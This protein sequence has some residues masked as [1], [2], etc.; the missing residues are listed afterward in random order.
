MLTRDSNVTNAVAM[1]EA[2]FA[3]LFNAGRYEQLIAGFYAEDAKLLPP[4]MPAVDGRSAIGRVFPQLAQIFSDLKI[5]TGPVNVS[6]ELAVT[7]GTYT[8]KL[9]LA[10]GKTV[11]DQGKFMEAWRKE[12]DGSWKCILDTFSS[13]NVH[14]D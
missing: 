14:T 11:N 8:A 9:K 5:T 1:A 12:S 3:E 4:N 10:S 7:N 13:D 2:R 6:G